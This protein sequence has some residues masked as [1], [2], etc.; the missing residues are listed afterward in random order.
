MFCK[1]FYN[2]CWRDFCQV[3]NAAEYMQLYKQNYPKKST[4]ITSQ[5]WC[6]HK[7]S[8]PSPLLKIHKNFKKNDIVILL[9][10]KRLL[11]VSRKI[12][13]ENHPFFCSAGHLI[14][15]GDL[16]SCWAAQKRFLLFKGPVPFNKIFLIGGNVEFLKAHRLILLTAPLPSHFTVPS[17]S[18]SEVLCTPGHLETISNCLSNWGFLHLPCH[19]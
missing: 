2:S 7:M 18:S 15:S 1:F 12:K 3:L 4:A 17:S 16:E 13:T 6:G 9:D 5:V 8:P 10:R 19:R 14:Q 11:S